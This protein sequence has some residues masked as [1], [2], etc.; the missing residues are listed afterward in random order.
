MVMQ[1]SF[2]S[3][4]ERA[5]KIPR[6]LSRP[7]PYIAV[8]TDSEHRTQRF[9]PPA[10]ESVRSMLVSI[11]HNPFATWLSSCRAGGLR[12]SAGHLRIHLTVSISAQVTPFLERLVFHR[13]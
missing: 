8:Q 2:G 5:R 7:F 12:Y 1:D 4:I 3:R 11:T 9:P 10:V 6:I 13:D